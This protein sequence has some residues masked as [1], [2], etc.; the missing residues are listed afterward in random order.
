MVIIFRACPEI[1]P[2]LCTGSFLFSQARLC[3]QCCAQSDISVHQ[4]RTTVLTEVGEITE[5][6]DVNLHNKYTLQPRDAL[7]GLHLTV[8]SERVSL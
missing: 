5:S 6:C 7:S 1:H 3:D 2:I 4:T 8:A